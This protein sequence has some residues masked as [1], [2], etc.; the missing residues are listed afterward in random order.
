MNGEQPDNP[1]EQ[2]PLQAGQPLAEPAS[3]S[4]DN[5][6]VA[7]SASPGGEDEA[8]REG[9]ARPADPQDA[10]DVLTHKLRGQAPSAA[11]RNAAD[12]AVLVASR[13]RT[14]LSLAWPLAL[15]LHTAF[16]AI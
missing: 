14:R 6:P 9:E 7:Q 12:A 15:R 3:S 4:Q 5:K 1:R 11:E 13:R 10:D 2:T 16:A 8:V